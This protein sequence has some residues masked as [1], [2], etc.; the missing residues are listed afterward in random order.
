[1]SAVKTAFGLPD[2]D[3]SGT[4]QMFTGCAM[5]SKLTLFLLL[6]VPQQLKN[7]VLNMKCQ[8]SYLVLAFWW[9]T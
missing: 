5:F 4:L 2:R 3:L 1:M 7:S 8:I 9:Y 6:F